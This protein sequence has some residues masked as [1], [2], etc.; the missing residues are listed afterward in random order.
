M[1]LAG[2]VGDHRLTPR[3]N[4]RHDGV[5]GAGDGRFVEE[6]RAAGERARP[7]RVAPVDRDVRT[8][9]LEGVHVRVEPAPAD[10][11]TSGR[12]NDR[13]AA[14]RE[15]RTGEED[16]RADTSAELLVELVARRLGRMDHDLAV[17]PLDGRAEMLDELEHRL[18]IEDAR[19]VRE[20]HRLVGQEAGGDDRQ[21]RV[22]VPGRPDMP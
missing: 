6:D 1:R 3:E 14:A 10:D 12:R 15:K 16:R 22:L 13:L 5:L 20:R 4:R 21:G 2:G 18:D 7:H 11:V 17:P 9:L 19:D 8:E